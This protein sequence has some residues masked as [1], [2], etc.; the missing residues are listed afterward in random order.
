MSAKLGCCAGL[1]VAVKQ[2]D[3]EDEEIV[4]DDMKSMLSIFG[5][6][7]FGQQVKLPG[8]PKAHLAVFEFYSIRD[9]AQAVEAIGNRSGSNF[10]LFL[11]NRDGTPA[12]HPPP[13]V[14]SAAMGGSLEGGSQLSSHS[15]PSAHSSSVHL[16]KDDQADAQRVPVP[17]YSNDAPHVSLLAAAQM[18]AQSSP[19]AT[20]KPG[21]AHMPPPQEW[22]APHGVPMM[23][24][25][26]MPPGGVPPPTCR[27]ADF[28]TTFDP[29]EAVAGGMRA[30]TTIMIRNI[31]CRWTAD[32]LLSVLSHIIDGTW[33]L[34]YMPCKNTAVANAGY[35]FMNFCTPQ[36][37]LR[38]YNAM[39]G[40]QWPHT[41]SGKI[42]EIRYARIQ[43]RKLLTHLNSSD[44]SGAAAFR[45]YL[46]YPSG[47]AIVVHGPNNAQPAL[48]MHP[49]MHV[50]MPGMQ[51]PQ[52]AMDASQ[53]ALRGMVPALAYAQPVPASA[54]VRPP[55]QYG[56][57]MAA[58]GGSTAIMDN[59][60]RLQ[61][62]EGFGE[63]AAGS[64]PM[65]PP[66]YCAPVPAAQH[67]MHMLPVTRG[68]VWPPP[69]LPPVSA[70]QAA[71]IAIASMV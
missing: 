24:G 22:P 38:L 41:R 4:V 1:V 5:A 39:H 6:V 65:Q 8:G 33:D 62:P 46:A 10:S 36:D 61:D 68:M 16:A 30:R 64:W 67:A 51:G 32:D 31:P 7:A 58:A 12:R 47:G 52:H 11:I 21:L 18:H 45:G 71:C 2:V 44:P 3:Q 34:L 35:A 60:V 28:L 50:P 53:H 9:A 63:A 69:T 57:G 40:H 55:V 25:M 13:T 23:P 66:A 70:S 59:A 27:P 54:A 15:E 29:S 14:P 48:P 19:L 37:T 42:C 20:S 49:G 56:P 43:G 26:P 17:V